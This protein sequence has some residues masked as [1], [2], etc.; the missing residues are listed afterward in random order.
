MRQSRWPRIHL[1]Y[2]ALASLDIFAIV[3]GLWLSHQLIISQRTS[4][5]ISERIERSTALMRDISDRMTDAQGDL[6]EAVYSGRITQQQD[7]FETKMVLARQHLGRVKQELGDAAQEKAKARIV[8]LLTRIER[9]LELYEDQAKTSFA[10]TVAGDHDGAVAAVRLSQ[11]RYATLRQYIRDI[12]QY[13]ALVQTAN[14]SGAA[15][16][17]KSLTSY[18]KMIAAMIAVI[19]VCVILY[20]HFI[21]ALM[22]R[23]FTELEA[24]LA[25]SEEAEATATASAADLRKVNDEIARLNRELAGN[26]QALKDAQDEIVRKGQMEQLG[27][28]TATIAHEIRNPL[29]SVRTS[30][31][32][33]ARKIKDTNLG[34]EVQ[35]DRINK[36]ID[37]CDNI[38]T[39][40]LDF[41]RNKPLRCEAA[42]LDSWLERTLIEEAG[43]LPPA[44]AICCELGLDGRHVPFDPGRLQRAVTNLLSNACE[45]MVGQG[46]DPAKFAVSD[47]RL[48]VS[49]ALLDDGVTIMVTDN[50][51]GIPDDILEKIREPLFTTKSFGTG[52]GIP[53]VEQIAKQ[54]NGRLDIVSKPGAGARFTIW[55]PLS[56]EDREAA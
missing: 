35:V 39:Q 3:A 24:A 6:I 41:S 51:P 7:F 22:K 50:G 18:E 20:G 38:I 45:A 11:S 19:V 40:L 5:A 37:R 30:A 54:H 2:F 28:L 48:V 1:V 29:G 13:M 9:A 42:D 23:K 10:L 52:L 33:L 25:R 32:V 8:V 36:G 14:R 31:F 16:T 15:A 17:L 56:A 49:T 43:R 47:P 21:G 55:L 46:D 12:N 34:V 44:V 53:A 26:M 4:L 27:R